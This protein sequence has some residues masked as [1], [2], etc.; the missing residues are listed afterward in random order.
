[1]SENRILKNLWKTITFPK[2][3]NGLLVF[4]GVIP[5][6]FISK[7]IQST[8]EMI[9]SICRIS[10]IFSIYLFLSFDANQSV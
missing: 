5:R 2:L 3:I 8:V 7:R 9:V 6:K 1:M 10:D 4:G